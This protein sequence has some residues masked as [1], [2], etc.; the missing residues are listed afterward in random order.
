M[1]LRITGLIAS[2]QGLV[3]ATQ[4][5]DNGVSPT[6]I[7]HLV[8]SGE[9]VVVR[10]G[11]YADG[12]AWRALDEQRGR[13][14]L[15]TRA[16]VATMRRNFVIS[17]DSAA[18]EHELDILVP[19]DPHVHITRAGHTGAWT[20]A[21]VKHHLAAY[22]E[23]QVVTIDQLKVLDIPRT[24]VDIAREHGEPYG[25]V[26]CDAAL[27]RGVPRSALMAAY[28]PMRSWKHVT[29]TR[30]AVEFAQP[31]AESVLE[32]RAG[33][34]SPPS[35]STRRWSSSPRLPARGPRRVG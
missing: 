6:T 1:D 28:E 19:P 10:R 20:K 13:H 35:G 26:A 30:R 3:T 2:G 9:L 14:R 33:C 32:T 7:R 25:E 5:L 11:V 4:L 27:R 12:E 23:E 34:W 17:H 21:G 18:H 15:R 31:L 16:A 29:R 8:R 24:V 22:T